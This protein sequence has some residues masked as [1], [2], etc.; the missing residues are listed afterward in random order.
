MGISELPLG[1]SGCSD[2]VIVVSSV[3][4]WAL[5][6]SHRAHRYAISMDCGII[7]KIDTLAREGLHRSVCDMQKVGSAA[8]SDRV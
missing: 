5:K 1:S 8:G 6:F 7:G 4:M 2:W 3:T